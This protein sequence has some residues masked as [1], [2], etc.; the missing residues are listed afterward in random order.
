[1]LTF[2]LMSAP[3]SRPPVPRPTAR[4]TAPPPSKAIVAP[5]VAVA[6]PAPAIEPVVAAVV[7][8]PV[9]MLPFAPSPSYAELPPVIRERMAST[10]ELADDDIVEAAP[11]AVR[12][13]TPPP[14][15]PSR[16][17]VVPKLEGVTVARIAPMPV[18]N[19]AIEPIPESHVQLKPAPVQAFAPVQAI[20]PVQTFAPAQAIAPVKAKLESMLDPSEALFDLMYDLNYADSH[21]QAARLCASAL[22][23]ALGARTVIVHA[24]DLVTHE[25]RA[26]GVHGEGEFD[27]LG[28]TDVSEDDLVASAVI[29]NQKPVT[30][31]FDGELPRL[32][33]RRLG[34]IGAP[35][36]LVAVPAMAW[37]R[38]VAVIE[39]IDADDRFAGRVADSAAYVA[40]RLAAFLSNRVAA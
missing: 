32:A 33:P 16:S 5:V 10:L 6:A 39:I 18:P 20:A 14:P 4:K 28:S 1:M 27:V 3:S 36:T 2:I 40:E 7:P 23:R 30:M 35:R 29:C 21:W 13:S 19:I 31:R 26:I 11:V 37:G 9:M 38:C 15:P 34:M 8:M 12:R 22:G 25:L 24:H 17:T